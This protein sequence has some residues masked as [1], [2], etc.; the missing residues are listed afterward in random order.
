MDLCILIKFLVLLPH[1]RFNYVPTVDNNQPSIQKTL[2]TSFRKRNSV[3]RID[4]TTTAKAIYYQLL[5]NYISYSS[6]FVLTIYYTIHCVPMVN[7][8]K[9]FNPIIHLRHRC[10]GNFLFIDCTFIDMFE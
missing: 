3:L 5:Y 9:K 7:P 1:Q 8:S 6:C 2:V 4:R 10:N